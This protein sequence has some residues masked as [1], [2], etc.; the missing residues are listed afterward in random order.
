MDTQNDMTEIKTCIA[1][2]QADLR[3][4][5]DRLQGY[6]PQNCIAHSGRIDQLEKDVESIKTE[7]ANNQELQE[8][9]SNITWLWRTA[10][11]ACIVASIPLLFALIKLV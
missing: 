4:L 10:A 8:L 1:T 7:K 5:I 2:I 11:G 9:K 3:N 6:V